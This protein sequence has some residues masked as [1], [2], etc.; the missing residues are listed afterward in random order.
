MSKQF[1]EA[2]NTLNVAECNS[3][4]YI[5]SHPHLMK[6]EFASLFCAGAGQSSKPTLP[7]MWS[8]H[9]SLVKIQTNGIKIG[10]HKI[11]NIKTLFYIKHYGSTLFCLGRKLTERAEFCGTLIMTFL[12]WIINFH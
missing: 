10:Y 6:T 2:T 8:N 9:D 12:T 4:R 11:Q 7:A 3:T 1:L 5:N